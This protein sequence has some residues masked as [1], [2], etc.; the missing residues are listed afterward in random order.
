M[1]TLELTKSQPN[2][3]AVIEVNYTVEE[4]KKVEKLRNHIQKNIEKDVRNYLEAVKVL[5]P[6]P[7]YIVGSGGTHIWVHRSSDKYQRIVY[8][9][10]ANNCQL[11]QPKQAP[12]IVFP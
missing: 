3:D 1:N 11:W 2:Y 7:D 9:G 10:S 12:K 6:Y 4:L 5:F 8:I